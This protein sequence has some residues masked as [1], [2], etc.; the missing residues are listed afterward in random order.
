[1]ND[2]KQKLSG[3]GSRIEECFRQLLCSA[4]RRCTDGQ[5]R[6]SV[7]YY[8]LSEPS[9]VSE[10]RIQLGKLFVTRKAWNPALYLSE[11]ILRAQ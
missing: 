2:G 7:I 10:Q 9:S 1:M 5:R 3:R 6:R 11:H 4:E 8:K